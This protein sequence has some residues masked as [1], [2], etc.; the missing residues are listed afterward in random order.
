M[1]WSFSGWN[2]ASC[3]MK[4]PPALARTGRGGPLGA[5]GLLAAYGLI[6]VLGGYRLL[7]PAGADVP[8]ILELML[9]AGLGAA[10]TEELAFRGMG[11]RLLEE[12]AGTWTASWC[13][14][15]CSECST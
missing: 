15:G 13:P 4:S 5:A 7:P 12:F 11:L 9:V 3:L 2:G 1:G 14:G 6:M 8:G 10:V